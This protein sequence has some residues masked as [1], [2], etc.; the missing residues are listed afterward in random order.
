MGAIS[1]E[2]VHP[3]QIVMSDLLHFLLHYLIL[4]NVRPQPSGRLYPS[5]VVLGPRCTCNVPYGEVSTM[6]M[7]YGRPQQRGLK[8]NP[9]L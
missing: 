8:G 4:F 2:C 5:N 7:E 9:S 6:G 3:P 1:L